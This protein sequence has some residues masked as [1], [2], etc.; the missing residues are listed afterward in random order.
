[1]T[2]HRRSHTMKRPCSPLWNAPGMRKPTRT[3]NAE[4][5]GTP[6]TRAAVIE[7]LVKGGFV[8]PGE[9][10][11]PHK[12]RYQPCRRPAEAPHFPKLTAEWENNLTQI[13]K[14]R[15]TWTHLWAVSRKWQKGLVKS[16]PFPPTRKKDLFK[17]ERAGNLRKS[18]LWPPVYEGKR[19]IIAATGNVPFTMWKKRPFL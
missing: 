3:R 1:M 13:A 9:A 6:A 4:G 16:Y 2:P 18:L 5:L 15:Q 12:G 19:T 17:P 10:A 14:G 7:K 11:Y 8:E